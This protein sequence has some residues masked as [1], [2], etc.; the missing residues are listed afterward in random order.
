MV[1]LSVHIIA[2]ILY[3]LD[4]FSP[5]GHFYSN[6]LR[7]TNKKKT[8]LSPEKNENRKDSL[9]FLRALWFTW[10]V[11]LSSGIGEGYLNKT[12]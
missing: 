4:R 12:H 8:N 2:L 11:L 1:L 9:N 10:S 5:F 3:L 6:R 7:N